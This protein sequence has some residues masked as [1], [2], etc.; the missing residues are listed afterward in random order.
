MKSAICRGSM[1]LGAGKS[2]TGGQRKSKCVTKLEKIPFLGVNSSIKKKRPGTDFVSIPGSFM[3][4]VTGLEPVR[5]RQRWI[6]SPLRL[7]FHHTGRCFNS[8]HHCRKNSKKK[9]LSFSFSFR[10]DQLSMD[11]C[12]FS[13]ILYTERSWGNEATLL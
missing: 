2:T 5:C 3:V 11:I 9:L 13:A 4:P 6:L 7:P 8:I 10:A 12:L 1:I